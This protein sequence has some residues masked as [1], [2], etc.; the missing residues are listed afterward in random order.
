MFFARPVSEYQETEKPW[1]VSLLQYTSKINSNLK[2]LWKDLGSKQ[3]K[4]FFAS[5]SAEKLQV[6]S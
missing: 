6:L 1:T 3:K 2:F 4:T 5:E